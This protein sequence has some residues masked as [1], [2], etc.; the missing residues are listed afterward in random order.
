MISAGVPAG[1]ALILFVSRILDDAMKIKIVF[2]LVTALLA[3][4]LA[5]EFHTL[6]QVQDENAALQQQLADL[7]SASAASS[8]ETVPPE[9]LK[10]L[11]DEHIELMRLRG[12]YTQWQKKSASAAS[13]A[14]KLRQDVAAARR[15]ADQKAEALAT[16][17]TRRNAEVAQQQARAQASVCINN[18]VKINGAKQQWALEA[19]QPV[20]ALPQ[21]PDL[22]GP[23]RYI[24]QKPVCPDGGVYTLNAIGV[25]PTCSVAGHTLP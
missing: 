8:S 13:E 9:E 4:A 1:H 19:K 6:Q 15:D 18:L 2:G 17:T 14:E 12:E 23:T 5:W 10:R 3:G 11:R 16:E 25:A 24:A 21:D 7:K 22:F 20:G